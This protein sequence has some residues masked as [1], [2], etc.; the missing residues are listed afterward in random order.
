MVTAPSPRRP[1]RRA[2][3]ALVAVALSVAACGLDAAPSPGPGGAGRGGGEPPLRVVASVKPLAA[4]VGPVLGERGT[5]TALVPADAGHHSYTPSPGDVAQLERADVY[6]GNGL[7][8]N[9][10]AMELARASLPADAP[11]VR[12]AEAAL[13]ADQL[14]AGDHGHTHTH[15]DGAQHRHGVAANPHTWLS[16][17]LAMDTVDHIAA[18][19]AEV[20][21]AGTAVYRANAADYRAELAQLHRSIA[22]AAATVPAD[23]RTI[24]TFHGAHRYFARAYGLALVG[25]VAPTDFSEPSAGEIADIIDYIEARDVPAV[26]GSALVAGRITD[27]V[28]AESG[29]VHGGDLSDEALPGEPGDPAHSYAGLIARNAR[30]IIA[31]LGGDPSGIAGP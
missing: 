20:D 31:G 6:F 12:L 2:A 17:P 15:D 29:A 8:L 14:I 9:P 22:A 24:V 13:D 10:P 18:V 21:P 16:V 26:F 3:A 28:V 1:R 11:L 19:L 4:L 7:G 25:A 23:Q 27:A 30:T 5:V